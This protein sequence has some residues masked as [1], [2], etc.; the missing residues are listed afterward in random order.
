[1][2][3]PKLSALFADILERYSIVSPDETSTS[4]KLRQIRVPRIILAAILS[5]ADDEWPNECCGVLAGVNDG[6]VRKR[7]PLPNVLASP[8]EFESE[9]R[10]MFAAVKDMRANGW[11]VLVVYHSHPS[12]PAIPSRTDLARS[13][14]DGVVNLIVSPRSVPPEL[15]AWM[16]T[17]GEAHEVVLIIADE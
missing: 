11:D 13:Y 6:L 8:V 4:V 7:Y 9:P 10:A 15:R 17:K 3:R 5:Q 12:S 14:G 16:Y 2:N 1:M